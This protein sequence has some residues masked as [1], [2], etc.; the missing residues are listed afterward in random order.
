MR[1]VTPK[2]NVIPVRDFF[3]DLILQLCMLQTRVII[4]KYEH[5][6][7]DLVRERKTK[8]L[9]INNFYMNRGN[10]RVIQRIHIYLK[11]ILKELNYT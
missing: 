4:F 9:K 8:L 7:S 3:Y 5:L 2:V 11:R 1:K 6:V 10:N